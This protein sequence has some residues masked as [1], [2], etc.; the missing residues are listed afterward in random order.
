M[1]KKGG[2]SFVLSAFLRTYAANIRVMKRFFNTAE[3]VKGR[4]ISLGNI[5]HI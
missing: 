3:A 4:V 5:Q 2:E 1:I